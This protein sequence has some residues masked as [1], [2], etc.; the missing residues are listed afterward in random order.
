MKNCSRCRNRTT[1]YAG[2][3]LIII[4]LPT[5]AAAGKISGNLT[6][7]GKVVPGADVLM[8]CEKSK[9]SKV[10]KTGRTGAF[11]ITGPDVREK[12]ALQVK[13]LNAVTVYSSTERKRVNL[14]IKDGRL[15]GDSQ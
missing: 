15:V 7:G 5:V 6:Q 12:C 1:L 11:E 14:E 9:F 3:M 8:I 10:V 4:L 2:L 13:K